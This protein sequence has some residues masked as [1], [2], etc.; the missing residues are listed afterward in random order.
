MKLKYCSKPVIAVPQGLAYG[1][2]A[3]IL[4]SSPRIRAS[5]DLCIGL[6]EPQVG[7]VPA[8][9]GVKEMT[10]RSTENIPE[11]V[12]AD[13]LPFLKRTH[14]R[15]LMAEV[16]RNAHEA[17]AAGFLRSTDTISMNR[18]GLLREA[19]ET[20]LHMN[21][22]GYFPPVPK[23]ILVTGKNGYAA[24]KSGV[25]TLREKGLLSDYSAFIGEKLAF[26]M[27]GGNLKD[28]GLVDEQ[29]LMDLELEV[30]LELA[31]ESRTR[32]RIRHMLEKGKP[33]FN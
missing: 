26:I 5:A 4:L 17:V 8:A 27:T 19:K 28:K 20:V 24:L 16:C 30:F 13:P 2:G 6:V 33:L 1:G 11:G 10:L 18:E 29:V 31:W 3:E 32:D 22:M 12:E 7:L 9:G 25:D 21:N 23:K 15:L 14:Q